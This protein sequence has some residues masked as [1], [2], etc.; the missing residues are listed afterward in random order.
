MQMPCITPAIEQARERRVLKPAGMVGDQSAGCT[1]WTNQPL[2][3]YEIAEHRARQAM[4]KSHR[5]N[6]D[7]VSIEAH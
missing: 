3:Y 7:S 4:P 1:C 5:V 6:H 2:R